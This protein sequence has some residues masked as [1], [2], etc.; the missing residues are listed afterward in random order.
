[1]NV[2][3]FF[4]RKK[5]S[6]YLTARMRDIGKVATEIWKIKNGNL[7]V[8]IQIQRR[9]HSERVTL[10]VPGYECVSACVSQPCFK[11]DFPSEVF[12]MVN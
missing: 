7:K 8:E 3:D 10:A 1:M 9:L 6:F 12:F 2:N 4:W 5:S 11:R